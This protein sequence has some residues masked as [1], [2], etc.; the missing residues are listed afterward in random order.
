MKGILVRW[1][2]GQ[3]PPTDSKRFLR[4]HA[5]GR[6]GSLGWDGFWKLGGGDIPLSVVPSL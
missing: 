5:F 2:G 4:N 6:G 3:I 1:F